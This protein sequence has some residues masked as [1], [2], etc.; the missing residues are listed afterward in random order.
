MLGLHLAVTAPKEAETIL[1]D[2]ANRDPSYSAAVQSLRGS[3][4]L[5]A[6]TEHPAYGWLM[7]GRSL[8]AIDQWALAEEAFHQSTGLS[9]EYAEAW[10][11]LSEARAHNGGSGRPE[12]ERALQ[13]SPGSPLVNALNAIALRRQAH[14][15]EALEFL[16]D[17]ALQ[18]PEEPFW[19]VEIANT[20]V[21]QGDLMAAL[22]Y[23]QRA[24]ALDDENTIYWQ[25][26]AMFSV[27][28]NVDIRGVGLPAA[29][30]AVM[31]APEDPSALDVMGW[32]LANLDDSITGERF[33]QQALA[34]DPAHPLANLHLAQIY[35]RRQQNREAYLYLKQAAGQSGS[36]GPSAAAVAETARRLLKQ[37]FGEDA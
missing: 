14:Y 34:L 13:L 15:A 31:L 28:Y 21:A 7:I 24:A 9:P 26:L 16:K 37:Y 12:M 23:F 29:R 3:L 25:A 18:E 30:Q 17:V 36:A 22:G 8:G 2:A 19:L 33:L 11:F 6:S 4:A 10:A 27:D 5:F 20:L 1:I 35:L 32:A